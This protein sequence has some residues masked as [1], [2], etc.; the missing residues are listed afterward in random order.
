MKAGNHNQILGT[1]FDEADRL[2]F[3]SPPDIDWSAET[4]LKKAKPRCSYHNDIAQL[5][6]A[7]IEELN[8]GDHLLIMSNGDFGGLKDKL[9]ESLR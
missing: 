4:V 9:L 2:F 8:E 7:I 5:Q 6:H 3:Y 1:A